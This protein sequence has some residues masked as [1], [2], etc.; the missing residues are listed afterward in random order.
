MA[1]QRRGKGDGSIYEEPERGRWVGVIDLGTDGSGRRQR[2]KV[3]G[4]TRKEV[5]AR[6]RTRRAELE[7][8]ATAPATMK[9]GDLI[10]QWSEAVLPTLKPTTA[11]KSRWAADL[12]TA[13]LGS[14][15]LNALRA[16]HVETFL[17]S[18][19]VGE[20]PRPK[21]WK[22]NPRPVGASSVSLL[23]SVLGRILRWGQ[24]RDLVAKNVASFSELPP[25]KG[26]SEGRALTGA[27]LRSLLAAAEGTR[28]A[29][30]WTV[31]AGH[32]LR[33]GEALGLTWPD[34]DF[35]RGVLHVRSALT[36]HA[37][38]A[39]LDQL[40]TSRSRRSLTMPPQVVTAL[41]AHRRVQ[42]E[43]RLAMGERWPHEWASLVFVSEAGTPLNGANTRREMRNLTARAGIEGHVTPY[44]L[45]HT[46]ASLMA[47]AG[48]PLEHIADVLGHD[49]MRMARLVY[50][51]ALSP[52]VS[53]GAG[54]MAEALG[55]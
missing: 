9:V 11:D 40:K 21:H 43:E 50:T 49:G 4:R 24:R 14:H 30:L 27:E 15:R 42:N 1:T 46:A 22:T 51:H 47:E 32:G 38:R 12:L 34:V 35:E 23:R 6:L 52:T 39:T 17:R 54:P 48:T 55:G 2:T 8:G 45:R 7:G 26:T 33:P 18:A 13:G 3:T 53:A 28:L 29:A 19:V 25:A 37:E 31:L 41:R 20:L 44:D 10:G 5:A 16:D 36:W